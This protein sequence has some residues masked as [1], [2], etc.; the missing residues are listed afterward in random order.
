MDGVADNDSTAEEKTLMQRFRA[1][2]PLPPDQFMAGFVGLQVAPGVEPPPPPE[3]P[4]PPWMAKP[5][6]AL[7]AILQAFD[8]GDLDVDVLRTFDRPVYFALGGRSN[9][10]YYGRMA[11]QHG[12]DLPRLH[13]RDFPR[14][15]PLRPASPDR[16]RPPR[17]LAAGALAAS[18]FSRKARVV[19]TYP[20]R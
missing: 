14:A 16:A 15:P 6:A 12:R 10:D 5:P 19:A 4:P 20:R 9:P 17:R 18:R 3:G 2:H 11:N 7:R 1:L 8:S 13:D